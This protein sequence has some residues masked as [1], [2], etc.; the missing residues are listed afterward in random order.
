MIRRLAWLAGFVASAASA[1]TVLTG[2]LNVP[3]AGC[4]ATVLADGR[5]LITG[6]YSTRSLASSELFD[7]ASGAFTIGPDM[8]SA[9]VGHTATALADG[10]VLI[11]GGSAEIFDGD[12]FFAVAG[13]QTP[14]TSHSAT[15]LHDG[16]VL[17]A[18]GVDQDGSVLADAELFDP[19]TRRF[20]RVGN[21]TAP[22]FGH[23][24]ALLPDGRV[25][26]AG[27]YTAI[28]LHGFALSAEI[29]DP[30]TKTFSPTNT[31]LGAHLDEVIVLLDGRVLL[32][33]IDDPPLV[34]SISELFDSRTD[35]FQPTA[36]VWSAR[37]G[38]KAVLLRNGTVL[39]AGGG[40]FLA[41]NDLEIFDPAENTYRS[42]GALQIARMKHAAVVLRDGR[43]LFIGGEDQTNVIQ[44]GESFGAANNSRHRAAADVS[45]SRRSRNNFRPTTAAAAIAAL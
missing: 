9:H 40:S 22:R 4:A 2:N 34:N 30:Q 28:E 19:A 5:V 25:L 44:T 11:A 1:Q 20:V 36:P 29:Y 10:E 45:Q 23:G 35:S 26:I 33:G 42:A 27:G 8:Q 24:A 13:M 21:M 3:R 17:L 6:G 7:P 32:V 16:T 41:T 18:G 43:S 12:T 15:L 38:A 31:P 39:V 14:R 37:F